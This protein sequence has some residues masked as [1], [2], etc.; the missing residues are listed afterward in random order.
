MFTLAKFIAFTA[1]ASLIA[2][3]TIDDILAE[4]EAAVLAIAHQTKL[5]HRRRCQ[6]LDTCNGGCATAACGSTF[7]ED[8]QTCTPDFGSNDECLGDNMII[9]FEQPYIRIAPGTDPTIDSAVSADICAYNGGLTDVFKQYSSELDAWMYVGTTTGVYHS[10]PGK[11]R[12]RS[13]GIT[14]ECSAYDPRLRPW[15]V[16][17]ASGPKTVLYVV[18]TSGLMQEPN[19]PRRPEGETRLDVTIAAIKTSLS[20]LTPND[21]VGIVVFN[22][23]SGMLGNGIVRATESNVNKLKR[24]LDNQ[25]PYGYTNYIPA[26]EKAFEM[27][28]DAEASERTSGCTTSILFLTDGFTDEDHTEVLDFV[29][30]NQAKLDV[31]VKMFTYS[32]SSSAEK[33]LP[34]LLACANDGV[35]ER[36]EDGADPLAAMSKFYSYLAAGNDTTQPV[37]SDI[38]ED[39]DGL[40]LMVTVAVPIRVENNGFIQLIGVAGADVKMDAFEGFSD[41]AI[42]A[43]LA[44]S[45][46]CPKYSMSACE[47]QALRGKEAQCPD[48]APNLQQCLDD[49][50]VVVIDNTC[51][52]SEIPENGGFCYDSLNV[53]TQL[54]DDNLEFSQLGCCLDERPV[55]EEEG[56][57]SN[58]WLWPVLLTFAVIIAVLI[59]ALVIKC[60]KKQVYAPNPPPATVTNNYYGNP[61]VPS[62]YYDPT[63]SSTTTAKSKNSSSSSSSGAFSSSSSSNV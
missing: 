61:V 45:S 15:Y 34:H 13:G 27:L 24:E 33:T 48:P 11:V 58:D 60:K 50:E 63:S 30:T 4:K 59:V 29:E 26:F 1:A 6:V 62:P 32:M 16:A 3:D 19:N 37:W 2:A 17:A 51:P 40:G 39:A 38:Y 55:D 5:L 35:W 12:E 7:N 21:Y 23:I 52:Y 14:A 36:I 56:E 31:P 9:D 42:D 18:D 54:A 49:A 41:R 25:T 43:M 10:Y 57:S 47:L 22:T 8:T 28:S 44:R 53:R 20:T 46:V